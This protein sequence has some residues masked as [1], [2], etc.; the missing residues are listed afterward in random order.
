MILAAGILVSLLVSSQNLKPRNFTDN[1]KKY[2]YTDTGGITTSFIAHYGNKFVVDSIITPGGANLFIAEPGLVTVYNFW[3]IACKPCIAEMPALNQLVEK[4]K[5]DSVRFIAIT[6][7]SP[8]KVQTFLEN[9]K[10]DFMVG[11]LPHQSITKIKKLSFYPFT[12]VVDKQQKLSFAIAG[13]PMGKNP[14]KEIFDILDP[15]IQKALA[16]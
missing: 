14:S 12:A 10:F 6:Y 4:Y 3:F 2:I 15:Q 7:D 9:N 13:K 11:I 5:N 8:D 16:H 1:G